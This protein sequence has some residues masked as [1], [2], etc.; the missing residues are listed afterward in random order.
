M[1][2]KKKKMNLS[3]T[4]E[5]DNHY[6]KK[7]P[8]RL[9]IDKIL[10]FTIYLTDEGLNTFSFFGYFKLDKT[11]KIFFLFKYIDDYRQADVFRPAV[12]MSY[13]LVR[14]D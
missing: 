10:I 9:I 8:F 2:E 14:S 1:G 3:I 4:Q 12:H 13:V 7:L 11:R 6:L 5:T